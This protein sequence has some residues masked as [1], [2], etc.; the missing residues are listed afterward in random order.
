MADLPSLLTEEELADLLAV[1]Q[2]FYRT[3]AVRARRLTEPLEWVSARGSVLHAEPGDWLLEDERG[4]WS[5]KNEAFHVSCHVSSGSWRRVGSVRAAPILRDAC[6]S[7]LEGVA[8]AR[9]GDLLCVGSLPGE[10]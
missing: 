5:V 6:V 3:G 2:V 10:H 1:S 4:T 8:V 7:T 9:P